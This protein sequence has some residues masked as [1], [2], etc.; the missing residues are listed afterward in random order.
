VSGGFDTSVRVWDVKRSRSLKV[1]PGHTE[2]V[3]SAEFN[4][5]GTLIVSSGQDGL[6]RIWDTATGQCLKTITEDVPVPVSYVQFSPNGK[7]LLA[8]TLDS[9]LRLW[10]YS[11]GK[12]LKVYTGHTNVKYCCLGTFSVTSNKYIVNGSEDTNI[13][14]WDVQSQEVV[15][16]LTGHEGMHCSRD[17]V[18]CVDSHPYTSMIASGSIESDLSIKLWVEDPV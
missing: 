5:D 10:S 4:R 8:A 3:T 11:S 13:Y 16:T 12:C 6:I 14:I 2:P 18:M 1:L 7:Y 9:T 17:V 15:Q